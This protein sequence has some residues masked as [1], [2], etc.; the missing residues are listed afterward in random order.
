[1]PGLDALVME[2]DGQQMGSTLRKQI[3]FGGHWSAL[4]QAVGRKIYFSEG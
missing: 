2:P 3:L 1:M 4:R